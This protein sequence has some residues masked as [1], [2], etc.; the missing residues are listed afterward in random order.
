MPVR[1]GAL[2]EEQ[3]KANS[4]P[5]N[6]AVPE[7]NEAHTFHWTPLTQFWH[8]SSPRLYL[9]HV[10][11]CRVTELEYHSRVARENRERKHSKMV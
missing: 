5:D 8:T 9:Y 11:V 4:L 7:V 10:D 2:A 6:E 3:F 1:A